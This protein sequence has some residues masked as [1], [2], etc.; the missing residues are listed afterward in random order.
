M[1]TCV[2]G[3]EGSGADGE[4]DIQ[5]DGKTARQPSRQRSVG[6]QA[7]NLLLLFYFS[8]AVFAQAMQILLD[9][10]ASM[11][12]VTPQAGAL[13]SFLTTGGA[14]GGVAVP[15]P[16]AAASSAAGGAAAAAVSVPAD[17]Q[18]VRA[19]GKDEDAKKDE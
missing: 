12:P 7:L 4:T 19:P 9:R 5:A 6:C 17:T 16:V 8:Q 13:P 11:P 1:R 18:P 10:N 3:A 14:Q 2:I 15:V